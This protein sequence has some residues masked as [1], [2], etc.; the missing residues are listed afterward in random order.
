M[1]GRQRGRKLTDVLN[2][3][4]VL[5][6]E[7]GLIPRTELDSV[8]CPDGCVVLVEEA[9]I[10]PVG[11]VVRTLTPLFRRGMGGSARGRKMTC[12]KLN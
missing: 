7:D 6:I 2:V 12:L 5:I 4:E 11:A 8:K 9:L 10:R 3:E 1:T